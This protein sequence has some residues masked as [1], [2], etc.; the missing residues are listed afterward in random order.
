MRDKIFVTAHSGC[1]GY[2]ANSVEYI[3]HALTLPI[4][5]LEIDI[6]K[7]FNGALILS[8]N[9]PE[10]DREY[11]S[12]HDAFEILRDARIKIN[13]DLKEPGLEKDIISL[14]ESTCIN[15]NRIIFTGT[16]TNWKALAET[17]EPS[18]IWINPEEIDDKFYMAMN[19]E[20]VMTQAA[21]YNYRV[22]NLDY[23]F[24][25]SEIVNL[26]TQ[27]D[28][29]ISLWTIDNAHEIPK[30]IKNSNI[31]NITTNRPAEIL[32]ALISR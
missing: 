3:E 21:E 26:T 32:Q 14:A 10:I 19:A 12:L 25:T 15:P 11:I 18:E 24:L 2:A 28:L 6:R 31:V 8:H 7:N 16:L 23:T 9:P 27:H 17:L 13:C 29:A 22:I 20:K 30:G 5:A 1:D 4:Y